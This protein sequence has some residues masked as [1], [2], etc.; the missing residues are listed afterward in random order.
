[1]IDKPLIRRTIKL[2]WPISLQNILTNMLAMVD[3]LMVSHLGDGAI[4]AV[5]LGNRVLFV[6][7]VII[8]GLGWGVGILA[9]QYYGAGK[10]EKITQCMLMASV[11]SFFLLCP[12]VIT[13]FYT[14]YHLM[15][16]GSSDAEVISLGEN[17]LHITIPSLIFVAIVTVYE[18]A[19]RSVN[20]VK[21]PLICASISILINIGLN[22]WLINGGLG[23]PALGVEGAAW[24]TAISRV[25]QL[26]LLLYLLHHIRHFLKISR[27]D[28][29][30]KI[31][32]PEWLKL[33]H[34]VFP[35]MF[36]FAI[37]AIGSFC[38]QLIFGRMGT[39]E[40]AV[41]SMLM[42]LEGMF[43]SLFFGIASACSI[44]VGQ[45]LGA[46]NMTSAWQTAKTFVLLSPIV[47]IVLGGI[48]VLLRD[49]I[50]S[51]YSGIS[52]S[53]QVLA[54][55]VFLLIA[56]LSWLKVI[57]MT[58]AMGVLRA[59]GDNKYCLYTDTIGMWLVSLPLTWL[60][61]FHW[62]FGLL[63]VA[64]IAYSEEVTKI[65]LFGGRFL[66]HRWMKNL[67]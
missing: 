46:N 50:L 7:M 5:G 8:L 21:L 58:L 40:L 31:A 17:Y 30:I 26:L 10:R 14:S 39:N 52:D 38:Y 49:V 22:Y 34:L 23:I 62:Q 67:S 64:A 35:M 57:N 51:P 6:H 47:A 41:I 44:Q 19:L 36:S 32:K 20:Q 42:P 29:T 56:G 66:S 1:M 45:H 63:A 25:L 15:S 9:A 24:A 27:K 11:T 61:A 16:F 18:N 60:A 53:T 12:I 13:N 48:L 43:I 54:Q 59:G 37:W 33:F 2:G 3:V 65:F 4:A 28:L 55:N